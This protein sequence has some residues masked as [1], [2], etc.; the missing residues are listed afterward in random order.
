MVA[1]AE[2]AEVQAAGAATEVTMMTEEA[3]V[4]QEEGE[5][6]ARLLPVPRLAGPRAGVA[7]VVEL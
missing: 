1:A 2:V 7:V 6:A 3:E 4:G 5:D